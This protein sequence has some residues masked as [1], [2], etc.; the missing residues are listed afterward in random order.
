MTKL[1]GCKVKRGDRRHEESAGGSNEPARRRV[2]FATA[3]R[4]KAVLLI[5]DPTI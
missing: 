2:P 1:V 3:L 5:P 4:P